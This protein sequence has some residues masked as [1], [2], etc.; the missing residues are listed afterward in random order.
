MHY[1]DGEYFL[2]FNSMLER[3]K[4]DYMR[5]DREAAMEKLDELNMNVSGI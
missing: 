4:E 1:Y 5:G 3:I 2:S